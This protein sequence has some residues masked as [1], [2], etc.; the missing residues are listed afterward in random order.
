MSQINWPIPSYIGE[1]YTAPNGKKWEWNGYAWDF[2]GPDYAVGPTGPAGAGVTN[3]TYAELVSDIGSNSLI[4]G[5]YYLITDFKTCYDQPDFDYD[6][7]PITGSN[8][9]DSSVEPIMVFATSSNTISE[10]AYQPD[11]PS[12]KIKYDW[13]YSTTEVT[14]GDAYGRIKE[15]IDE[16]NNRTDYDHRNILFKRYRLYTCTLENSLRINGTVDLLFDGTVNGTDTKFTD[17]S[18]GDII[19]IDTTPSYYEISNIT[20]DSTMTVIGDVIS[21][22]TGANFFRTIEITNGSGYFSYKRTNVKTDDYQEYTTFGDALLSNYAVN[23]YVGDYVNDYSNQG[24]TFMLSNNVFLEGEY[25]NNKLGNFCYNNT[26]GTDNSN[27]TFGN[28]C[29]EN[30]SSNDMDE[31]FIGDYFTRNIINTNL[32]NN[33]IGNGFD[34]N[35]LL[36]ENGN[37]F[38]DNRIE[39]SF[40]SNT[41][42]MNFYQN[43]IGDYFKGNFIGDYSNIDN[44]FSFFNNTINNSLQKTIIRRD[45]YENQIANNFVGCLINGDF[46][47]NTIGY[48]FSYNIIS[49]NFYGN[50][51]S[52]HFSKNYT[53]DNFYYNNI[54]TDF[55]GNITAN[56]FFNN[57][58]GSGFNANQPYNYQYFSFNDLSTLLDRSYDTMY[59]SISSESLILE[60]PLIMRFQGSPEMFFRITFLQ[61][62]PAGTGGGAFSYRRT[63]ID[64]AGND[65]GPD[66]YFTRTN[67]GNEVDIIIPGI[68]EISRDNSGGIY[69]SAVEGSWSS[70]SP[71]NTEWN[72]IYTTGNHGQ[73]FGYNKIGNNF[74]SNVIGDNFGADGKILLGNVIGDEFYS[75]T[76]IN[77]FWS[78]SIG[79]GMDKNIIDVGFASN[80]IK[81]DFKLNILGPYFQSNDIGN[82]FGNGS[83]PNIIGGSFKNNKI[84]DFFGCDL[85]KSKGGNNIGVEN[86]IYYNTLRGIPSGISLTNGGS[87]Y[88]DTT[89]VATVG[90]SGSGLT[91]DIVT[92]GFGLITSISINTPGTYYSVG[93]SIIISGG[94]NDAT[95]DISTINSFNPGDVLD[96]GLGDT[97]EV[98]VDDPGSSSMT[99]N[100]LI[101]SF[102][103]GD[104]LDNGNGVDAIFDYIDTLPAKE[105]NFLNNVIGDYFINNQIGLNFNNNKIGNYFGNTGADG[106]SN[107]ILDDFRG[108]VIGNY[109]GIDAET[110]SLAEGGNIIRSNF[111]ENYIGDSFTYNTTVDTS[112]GG[113]YNNAIGWAFNNNI[114]ADGFNYNRIGDLF[115]YNVLSSY[116]S[117]N[118]IGF[119]FN[120]NIVGDNSSSNTIGDLSWFNEIGVNFNHNKCGNFFGDFFFGGN[121]IADGAYDNKFSDHASGNVIDTGFNN[122]NLSVDFSGNTIGPDFQY[123]TSQYP[124]LGVDFVNLSPYPTHVYKPYTCTIIGDENGNLKLMFVDSAP[125]IQIVDPLQ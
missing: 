109:F 27:N 91:V 34:S 33:N 55:S 22:A 75:N 56:N 67:Y 76:I 9:K 114:I 66:I 118:N 3:V 110:P 53:Y 42:Y 36:S 117:S 101:G 89:N 116:F 50:D 2:I 7:N 98:L 105:S 12:D 65:I 113:Y 72:S 62:T 13:T 106:I 60:M 24:F 71:A 102:T 30:A 10:D 29:Y 73:N 19:Y 122:N 32:Q 92:D 16:W 8:Y 103:F 46:Y 119:F 78:N 26:F 79:N 97:C 93:D 111:V 35:S 124:V 25:Q 82:F 48:S 54:G 14:G 52:G 31:N 104:T 99:V 100:V 84:G 123:N 63:E 15:R 95:F 107:I 108:N 4:E 69:N 37:S 70:T 87:G 88:S 81:N 11:Y 83:I 86:T 20:D 96:N 28:F 1:I 43:A 58:I 39:N 64:S 115:Q 38:S 49:Y 51:I 59:N 18:V 85:G 5:S 44:S 21:P 23:N 40:N 41:I 90:G 112:G 57:Q 80:Y 17:L 61:W 125:S 68:L 47:Q 45:F 94:G 6:N 121:T 74:D 120:V 77:N